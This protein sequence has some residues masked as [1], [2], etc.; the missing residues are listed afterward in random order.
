MS[1]HLIYKGAKDR[2]SCS[3]ISDERKFRNNFSKRFR[4]IGSSIYPGART[5]SCTWTAELFPVALSYQTH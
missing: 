3:L 4:K 5:A 1:L 2:T